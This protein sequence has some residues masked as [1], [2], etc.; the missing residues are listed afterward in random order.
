MSDNPERDAAAIEDPHDRIRNAVTAGRVRLFADPRVLD[1]PGSPV[2]QPLDHLAPLLGLMTLAMVILL[3]AG[4]AVGLVSMTVGVL[5]HFLT[6]RYFLA[7]RLRRRVT[8]FLLASPAH[9]QALWRLG[10][11]ALVLVGTDEPPCLAPLGNWRKFALRNLAGDPPPP[12]PSSRGPLGPMDGS[13]VSGVVLD[14]S[15]DDP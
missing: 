3:V 8:T 2:H 5:I 14:Q 4:V 1:Y 11:I 10:G 15:V 13:D 7:W 6:N 9:W 12:A